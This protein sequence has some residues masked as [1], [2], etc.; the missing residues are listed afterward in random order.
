MCD[1]VCNR[2]CLVTLAL[3]VWKEHLAEFESM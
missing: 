2:S 3:N 1:T